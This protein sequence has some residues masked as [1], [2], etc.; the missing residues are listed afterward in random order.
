MKHLVPVFLSVSL[1]LLSGCGNQQVYEAIQGNQRFECHK[2]PSPEYEACLERYE[3]SYDA[4]Q[5]SREK[6]VSS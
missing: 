5:E 1:V 3:E 2:L 6:A 4:Y